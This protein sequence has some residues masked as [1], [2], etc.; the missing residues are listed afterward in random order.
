M[1]PVEQLL[2]QVLIL[3]CQLRDRDALTELIQQ[4]ERPLRY[5]VD[6]LLGNVSTVEEVLQETWLAVIRRIH[7]LKNPEAFSAWLY[8]IARNKA[9]QELRRKKQ[10]S[11]LD[12]NLSVTDEK[13]NDAFTCEDAEKVRSSL[14]KLR[15]EHKEVLILRFLEQ[16]SYQ[17][18]AEIL[19]CSPG[20][21]RSRIY[22]AKAALKKEME[23]ET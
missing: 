16:M 6:N 5:F 8:R 9:Y 2:Q 21:V 12:E 17:D 18:I 20:T 7:T 1:K 11:K 13:G 4:Y 10:L 22:Y 14:T 23:T 3:R 19:A 15:P